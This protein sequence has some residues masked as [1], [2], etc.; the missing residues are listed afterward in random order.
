MANI[1]LFVKYFNF[2]SKLILMQHTTESIWKACRHVLKSFISKRVSD[3]SEADDL[4]QDV[5][6]KIHKKI[7][8]LQNQTNIQSWVYQ[9]AR[10]T[11][12][13]Y[14]RQ[15]KIQFEDIDQ[16][17]LIISEE[18]SEPE[19]VR[20]IAGGLGKMIESLPEKYAQ[21]ILWADI[22]G[23]PQKELAEKLGISVSGAKSRV[24][25]GREMLKDKLMCCVHYEFDRYGT[26]IDYHP[27]TCCCCHQYFIK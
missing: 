12:T 3:P 27:V 1:I 16:I 23:L 18:T 6:I 13:D 21:A 7:D 11:I 24:Q 5:F 17:S 22:K 25:R 8:T 26:I 9:I 20:E 19:P 10:N 2:E 15:K 4:L 14:Y